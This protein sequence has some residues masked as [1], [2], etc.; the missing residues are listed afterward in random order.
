MKPPMAKLNVARW[1]GKRLL[2]KNTRLPQPQL[3]A[4]I[5]AIIIEIQYYTKFSP[6]FTPP[7]SGIVDGRFQ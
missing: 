5:F 1:Y 2:A 4:A 7:Q 3:P 6:Y